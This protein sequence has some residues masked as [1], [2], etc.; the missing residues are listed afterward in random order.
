ML[1]DT[2]GPNINKIQVVILKTFKF[3]ENQRNQ[4]FTPIKIYNKMWT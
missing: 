4:Y 2:M 1:I 3:W